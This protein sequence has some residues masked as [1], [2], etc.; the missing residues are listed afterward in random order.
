MRPRLSSQQLLDRDELP[1][2]NSLALAAPGYA[3]ISP[4]GRGIDR[5]F[6]IHGIFQEFCGI[7]GSSIDLIS[8][9]VIVA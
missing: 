2:E 3:G 5:A 8:G 4:V 9:N 1:H 7:S 6:R